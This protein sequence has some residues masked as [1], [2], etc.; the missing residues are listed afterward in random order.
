MH[1][2]GRIPH[3]RGCF[4]YNTQQTHE[5]NSGIQTHDPTIKQLYLRPRGKW[6]QLVLFSFLLLHFINA[7]R[8]NFFPYNFH[9]YMV[10][11]IQGCGPEYFIVSANLICVT[12][13]LCNQIKKEGTN[14]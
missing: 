10:L 4:L 8:E 11:H 3:S 1:T 5:M 13:H 6:D 7:N 12:F 9:H 14:G 2:A